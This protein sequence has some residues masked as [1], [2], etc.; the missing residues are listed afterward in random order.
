MQTTITE[1]AFAW[2]RLHGAERA[3]LI[4]LLLA[5][6][7]LGAGSWLKGSFATPAIKHADAPA[8][9]IFV[10]RAGVAELSALPGIGSRKA[11]RIMDARAK[12]PLKSIDEL[13]EAAGGIAAANLER[14]KPFVDFTP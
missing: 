5:A 3:A 6:A 14:M 11:Q 10:N 7:G 12:A 1:P 9:R 8:A 2:Y 4:V 13:A